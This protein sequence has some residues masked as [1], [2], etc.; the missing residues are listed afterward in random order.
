MDEI[1][2]FRKGTRLP[3][4]VE[5]VSVTRELLGLRE[6]DGEWAV[7]TVIDAARDPMSAMHDAFEWDATEAA[8]RYNRLQAFYLVAALVDTRTNK[9][10]FSSTYNETHDPSG[11]GRIR[12]NVNA[13]P[14]EDHSRQ[15]TFRV[16]PSKPRAE[17]REEAYSLHED[18]PSVEVLDQSPEDA[19][20]LD[21]FSRWVE[22]HK[23]Q[24]AV[25]HAAAKL[26]VRYL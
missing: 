10:L 19:R 3:T 20:A 18:T 9:R 26:L 24:P 8:Y 5:P 12:F 6:T 1:V 16:G 15:L 4:T 14:P 11:V 25:L 22:A 7:D 2:A 17:A 13:L 21:V 23:H